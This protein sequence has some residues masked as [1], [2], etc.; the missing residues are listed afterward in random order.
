MHC[1]VQ[2]CADP[3]G[4]E[5]APIVIAAL[6]DKVEELNE[7]GT[8]TQIAKLNADRLRQGLFPLLLMTA[9]S[10]DKLEKGTPITNDQRY[11]ED[12]STAATW[13][14][15]TCMTAARLQTWMLAWSMAA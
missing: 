10:T 8:H 15:Q 3:S 4:R 5:Q 1:T 14:Q 7:S 6:R 12:A 13:L 11:T 2:P 9:I